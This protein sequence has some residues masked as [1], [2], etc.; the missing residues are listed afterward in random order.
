MI[1]WEIPLGEQS[2]CGFESHSEHVDPSFER[3]PLVSH[4]RGGTRDRRDSDSKQHSLL[5]S[6]RASSGPPMEVPMARALPFRSYRQS[7][8][9][10]ARSLLVPL[11]AW[12]LLACDPKPPQGGEAA[13]TDTASRVQARSPA[14]ARSPKPAA[15]VQV[16]YGNQ[17]VKYGNQRYWNNAA[18]GHPSPDPVYACNQE[19][20][21][22]MDDAPTFKSER[23]GKCPG[24]GLDYFKFTWKGKPARDC[25]QAQPQPASTWNDKTLPSKPSRRC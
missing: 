17:Q 9:S 20:Q 3:R 21:R 12:S 24:G 5:Y 23:L 2:P 13:H 10:L 18:D 22:V 11:A 1:S 7:T 14:R 6:S 4:G 25:D 19:N 16:D 8:S 15:V